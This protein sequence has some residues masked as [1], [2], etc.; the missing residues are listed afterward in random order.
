MPLLL[1]GEMR[2]GKG[3]VAWAIHEQ[4]PW[5]PQQ[6]VCVN[7]GAFPQKLIR[8]RLLRQVPLADP[9]THVAQ[10]DRGVV[11]P[12]A[13]SRHAPYGNLSGWE[14]TPASVSPKPVPSAQPTPG[15]PTSQRA[16]R[17]PASPSRCRREECARLRIAPGRSRARQGR[18]APAHAPPRALGLAVGARVPPRAPLRPPRS[19]AHARRTPHPLDAAPATASTPCSVP[20][21]APDASAPS[22]TRT[23]SDRSVDPRDA[24]LAARIGAFPP[25]A[26]ELGEPMRDAE[27]SL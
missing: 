1:Q 19:Q 26:G 20:R 6:M 21:S 3:A 9:L 24:E 11:L 5:R 17:G 8:N 27:P 13:G 7:S 22:R 4:G 2:T 25:C 10:Q 18:H 12:T 15:A 16:S 14:P 23:S